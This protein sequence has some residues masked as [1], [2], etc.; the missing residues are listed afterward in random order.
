MHAILHVGFLLL[1]HIHKD[2][3]AKESQHA[4]T[5]DWITP[6]YIL[7]ALGPFDLDPCAS[8]NQQW[9][10]A[11]TQYTIDDDG[12]NQVWKGRVWCNPP[13]GRHAINWLEK[14]AHHNN[15]IAFVF[16][17]TDTRSFHEWVFPFAHSI[18]F[19]KGRVKFHLHGGALGQSPPTPSVLIAYG[20]SNT[21]ALNQ[22]GLEG[23]LWVPHGK[24]T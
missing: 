15:G 6:R 17:R 13:Y 14:M 1:T 24:Q 22:S 19:L 12:L 4:N 7:D 20:E 9:R 23:A 21:N 16:A 3:R 18:L 5:H 2:M 11:T 10:T 8:L